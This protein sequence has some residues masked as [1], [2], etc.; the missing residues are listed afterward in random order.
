MKPLEF[1]S[2]G[3]FIAFVLPGIVAARA[4]AYL[5]P[6]L[7]RAFTALEGASSEAAGP[8]FLVTIAALTIGLT[9]NTVRRA[10]V[11]NVLNTIGPKR[12]RLDYSLLTAEKHERFKDAIEGVYRPYE[13]TANMALALLSLCVARAVWGPPQAGLGSSVTI[14]AGVLGLVM[15]GF[16]YAQLRE[17]YRVIGKIL[18]PATHEEQRQIHVHPT[19]GDPPPPPPADE[20]D[21]PTR[22]RRRDWP[23]E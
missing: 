2:F 8:I 7:Q 20:E 6:S 22:Y 1:M 13:F 4:L 17:S 19:T 5:V 15:L 21:Q 9:L 14:G 18:Q 23:Q 11:D 12:E 16:A 10:V 3:H